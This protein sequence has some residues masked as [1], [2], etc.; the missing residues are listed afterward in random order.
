VQDAVENAGLKYPG[1]SAV[2]SDVDRV[3]WQ[4]FWDRGVLEAVR[5]RRTDLT[6]KVCKK[7]V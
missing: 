2:A 7:L 1:E 6:M 4:E 3:A 5:F